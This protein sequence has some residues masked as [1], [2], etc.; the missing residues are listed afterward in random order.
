MDK[1]GE[2]FK[3][4]DD[5]MALCFTVTLAS[6]AMKRTQIMLKTQHA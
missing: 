6:P 3:V 1:Y 2:I 4:I 5:F